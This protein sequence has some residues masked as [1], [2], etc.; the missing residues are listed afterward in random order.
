MN[1]APLRPSDPLSAFRFAVSFGEASLPAAALA[2]GGVIPLQIGC[3]EVSGLG[4]TLEALPYQE[5]GRND[6]TLKFP[7]R[8]NFGNITF[9]RGVALDLS[10]FLWFD[11][12]RS[13]SFGTRRSVLIAHLD[14]QGLTSLVWYVH[15]AFPVAF[16]GPT[17]NASQN[18]VAIE[19][20]ELA[21]EGLMVVPGVSF[22]IEIAASVGFGV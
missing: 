10:L 5:G 16:N 7:T 13:G 19:S 11:K 15:R 2:P 4:G 1:F 14:E 3:Q 18:A 21:H 12:V 22:A 6:T 17:W 8:T 20:L 9:R